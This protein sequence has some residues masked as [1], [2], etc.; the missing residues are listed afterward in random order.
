PFEEIRCYFAALE[1]A[2]GLDGYFATARRV[3]RPDRV[4]FTGYLTHAEL[5]Y[6]VPCC[7]VAIIPSIVAEAGPLVFLEALA[8]GV[9]PLGT[10]FAGIAASIESVAGA[11]PAADAAPMRLSP[12]PSRTIADIVAKT[13]LALALGRRHADRLRRVVVTRHDWATVAERL[14]AELAALDS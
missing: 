5:A 1:A 8:S 14:A 7:D 3:V 12:D 11:L 4:I 2:G 13:P 10:D 6:L 9:F